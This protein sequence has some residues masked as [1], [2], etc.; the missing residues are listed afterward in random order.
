MIGWEWVC[1]SHPSADADGSK[2]EKSPPESGWAFLLRLLKEQ[3]WFPTDAFGR[4]TQLFECPVLDLAHAL[5]ADPEQMADLAEAVRTVASEAEA[6]IQ[7]L[8]FAGA[9]VFHEELERFLAFVVLVEREGLRIR[10]RFGQLE[11]AVVV[12]NGVQADGRAG[13]GLQVGQVFE[14][15]AG[16]GREFLWRRQVLAAVGEGFGFLLEQAEFLQVVRAEADQ[17]ALACHSDLQG[18][19]DPPR[20]IS[21]EAGAVAHVET[22][23]RLHQPAHSFLE[24]IGVGEAVVTETLGYVG[25]QTDIGA[26]EAVL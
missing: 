16:A 10:H 1:E 19:A 11:I 6:Q 22:V 14:A 17:V 21:G 3:G 24:K 7:N 15:A 18:L 13:G 9:E 25:C 2:N 20:R 12:E 5:L 23:D 8:P 4:G 26:R